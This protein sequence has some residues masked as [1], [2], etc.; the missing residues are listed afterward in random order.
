MEV[1][2]PEDQVIISK[3]NKRGIITFV[4]S[5]F[6]E[7]SGFSE[8]ECIGKSHNI[9]RHPETPRVLF[10][11]LWKNLK[12]GQPWGAVL[13]NKTKSNDYYW[14]DAMVTPEFDEQGSI[15]G[16]VSVRRKPKAED[17]VRSE[18][19]Y[20]DLNAG[21]RLHKFS[22]NPVTLITRWKISTRLLFLTLISLVPMIFFCS[23]FFQKKY[24]DLEF[25][26]KELLG[27]QIILNL[28]EETRLVAI[29][30]GYSTR[31]LYQNSE[32]MKNEILKIESQIDEN[33]KKINQWISLNGNL[34]SIRGERELIFSEWE[35]LKK[36]NFELKPEESYEKHVSII[37][38]IILL[39]TNIGERSNLIL[40]PYSDSYFLIDI[41]INRVGYLVESLGKLRAQGVKILI[42]KDFSSKGTMLLD[43]SLGEMILLSNRFDFEFKRALR[44]N[45]KDLANIG[46]EVQDFFKERDVAIDLIQ[47]QL[48]D[49]KKS[50]LTS[51]DYFHKLT[52]PIEK[53][54]NIN[55]RLNE[56][57]ERKL[58]ERV[59][60]EKK[61][62]TILAIALISIIII[63]VL[64]QYVISKS[65]IE[66]IRS[67]IDKIKII[68]RGGGDLRVKFDTEIQGEFG[69]LSKWMNVYTLN[70]I[71]IIFNI[72]N[73]SNLLLKK[74]TQITEMVSMYSNSTQNQ[75]ATTEEASAATEEMSSSI[76]SVLSGIISE[77]EHLKEIERE[78]INL[79]ATI[80]EVDSAIASLNSLASELS[81]RAKIG[82]KVTKETTD[83]INEVNSKSVSIDRIVD[84]IKEISS[85]TNLLALNAAIEAARA[86]DS[87]KG[88]AIVADEISKLASQT[89]QNTKSIQNL[90]KDT[91]NSISESV[92]KV[93]M[94]S[95][96]L[97]KLIVDV[98]Q[99]QFATIQVRG[100][101]QAQSIGS[102][103]IAVSVREIT[104]NSESVVEAAEQQQ[105]VAL[106]IAKSAQVITQETQSI[107]EGSSELEIMARE[108]E[109]IGKSLNKMV[110]SFKY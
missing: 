76:S 15:I 19:L 94:T 84:E 56:I 59:E 92:E 24:N 104:K 100:A 82:E 31:F 3:T 49:I 37:N 43:Q 23:L 40:D 90:T 73:D 86:G 66:L 4:N 62:L 105:K 11:D 58:T 74:T 36:I 25:S 45:S 20:K 38:K 70:L 9:V 106:E 18:K 80:R 67:V 1:K 81:E 57:L 51:E 8:D 41:S 27:T 77:S 97:S 68:V 2:I 5:T 83:A 42:T 79:N 48:S 110:A 30:R 7:I 60:K 75:A 65:M 71:Q 16:Y 14:V 21:S 6:I 39:I 95:D 17:I 99:I 96:L 34:F 29:H 52:I 47:N 26:R 88:F 55:K 10:K 44:Y 63:F 54:F 89:D 64:L 93:K 103:S 22:I 13:K 61:E 69:E 108:M 46:N 78:T 101:Q 72:R 53:I 50:N 85:R 32:S 33:H 12:L 109:S 91:K 87:G 107:A 98:E 102:E 35:N 28:F